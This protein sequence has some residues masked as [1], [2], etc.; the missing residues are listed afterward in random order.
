MSLANESTVL[1]SNDESIVLTTHRLFYRT[2][3]VNKEMFLKDFV[4]Y[5]VVNR[6]S[7]YYMYLAIAFAAIALLLIQSDDG[8]AKNLSYL[9]VFVA[10]IAATMY[11]L[12]TRKFLKVSSNFGG[13]EFSIN[14][15]SNKSYSRFVNELVTNSENRKKEI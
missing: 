6:R 15:L 8:V 11:F 4:S 2:R 10:A 3:D 5:E 9:F 12:Y 14:Q 13:I 1:A 7:S